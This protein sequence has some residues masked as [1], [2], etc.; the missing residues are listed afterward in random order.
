MGD[1]IIINLTMVEVNMLE[2]PEE[3][4]E[5]G[6]GELPDPRVSYGRKLPFPL[7]GNLGFLL[8]N[9]LVWKARP[10]FECKVCGGKGHIENDCATKKTLD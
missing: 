2:E 8:E 1:F 6:K 7:K 3:Y 4:E 5:N 9:S 10:D